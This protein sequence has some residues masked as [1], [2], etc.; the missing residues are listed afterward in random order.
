MNLKENNKPRLSQLIWL[1]LTLLLCFIAFQTGSTS[2]Q[3][4]PLLNKLTHNINFNKQTS[5]YIETIH[6][7]PNI[8]LYNRFLNNTERTQIINLIQKQQSTND[9]FYIDDANP[10][11]QSMVRRAYEWTHYAPQHAQYF[12]VE[13]VLGDKG[14][15]IERED[16][17]GV[18]VATLVVY[19]E[20]D[21]WAHTVFPSIGV[22]LVPKPGDAVLVFESDNFNRTLREAVKVEKGDKLVM[23]KYFWGG[24]PDRTL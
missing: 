9:R 23:Y 22:K 15:V 24:R 17:W 7:T 1:T 12:Q 4:K 6:W 10:V 14:G 3:S 16:G 5:R 18:R 21:D 11:I 2:D 20:V 13:H 8:F 19:L